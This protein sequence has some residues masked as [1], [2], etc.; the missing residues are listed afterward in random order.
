MPRCLALFSGGLDSSLAIAMIRRQG[1]DVIALHFLSH[2]FGNFGSEKATFMAKQ[3]NVPI[4]TVPF[5]AQQ[6]SVTVNPRF[7]RGKCFNACIDCHSEM[8][9]TAGRLLEH[10]GADFIISGEVLG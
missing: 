7:G 2:F 10:Y 1:V 9:K 8:I 5:H 4:V 3:L 6:L